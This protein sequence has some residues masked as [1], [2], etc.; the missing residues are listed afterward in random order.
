MTR[1]KKAPDH[2]IVV[3]GLLGCAL[4]RIRTCGLLLR[5]QTLYP[6]SYEGGIVA[7][8]RV[9]IGQRQRIAWNAVRQKRC[10]TGWLTRSGTVGQFSGSGVAPRVASMLVISADSLAWALAICTASRRTAET[11]ACSAAYSAIGAP[12][13]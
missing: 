8:R 4:G 10:R 6:L 9:A 2:W 3:G 7:G 12:P 5:R 13:W 11:S 1:T